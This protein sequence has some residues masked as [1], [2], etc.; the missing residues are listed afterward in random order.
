MANEIPSA[1]RTRA[2]RAAR[3]GKGEGNDAIFEELLHISP[4]AEARLAESSIQRAIE[5]GMDPTDA[6]RWY[7]IPDRQV[8]QKADS[9]TFSKSDHDEAPRAKGKGGQL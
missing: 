8:E 2:R 5:G 3:L 7:G 4:E 6:H 9:P 1:V